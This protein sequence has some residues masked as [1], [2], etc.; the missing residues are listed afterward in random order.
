MII[1]QPEFWR[2]E[3]AEISST[4][5]MRPAYPEQE[6][7]ELSDGLVARLS[8]AAGEIENRRLFFS[9]QLLRSDLIDLPFNDLRVAEDPR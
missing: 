1:R 4:C 7:E 3:S 5:N 2:S 8:L 6:S 9:T